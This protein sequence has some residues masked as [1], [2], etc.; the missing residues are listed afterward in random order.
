MKITRKFIAQEAGVSATTVSYVINNTPS[1]RISESVK[2]RVLQVAHKYNYIPDASAKALVTGKTGNIGFIYKSSITDFFSDPFTHDVFTGLERELEK[3]DYSLMFALL[4]KSKGGNL[5][6]STKRML[7]GRFVDGVVIYGDISAEIVKKLKKAQSPFVL[8]DYSFEDIACNAVLPDNY[9]GAKQA[10]NYLLKHGCSNICCLNGDL[11][12]FSHPTYIERPK[13][14]RE[15]MKLAGK[16]CEVVSTLPDAD[17][18]YERVMELLRNGKCPDAFFCTG[19]HIAFGCLKAVAE[20]DRTLLDKVR[21]IGFDN[22]KWQ[23]TGLPSLSTVHVPK[24]ELGEQAI[25]MLI[26]S[27]NSKSKSIE[28]VRLKTELVIKET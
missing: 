23:E 16:P 6:N 5:S 9:D 7:S 26:A 19:D 21:I 27:I 10:V 2:K 15:A 17:G 4:K 28:T 25:K 11:E 14:Y 22:I 18:A 3:N 12:S 20:Y 8:I 1:T 13:G 24:I